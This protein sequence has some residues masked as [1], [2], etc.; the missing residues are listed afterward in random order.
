[1]KAATKYKSETVSLLQEADLSEELSDIVPVSLYSCDF[2]RIELIP[3]TKLGFLQSDSQQA[4][5]RLL[6]ATYPLNTAA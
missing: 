6:A 5:K 2:R 1:M 3:A 4:V